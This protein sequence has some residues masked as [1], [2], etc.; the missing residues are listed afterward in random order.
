MKLKQ[1]AI[2]CVERNLS[3]CEESLNILRFVSHKVGSQHRDP[4]GT[5]SVAGWRHC[6]IILIYY[7]V[8][9]ASRAFSVFDLTARVDAG[10]RC[11]PLLLTLA[12]FWE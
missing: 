10:S 2:S 9:C 3:V 5:L 8:L 6:T 7:S 1:L 4:T 11:F 12:R